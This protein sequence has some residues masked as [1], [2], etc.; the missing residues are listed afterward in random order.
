MIGDR[1]EGGRDE[2]CGEMIQKVLTK[3]TE[4]DDLME[5]EEMRC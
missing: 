3:I 2:L 1:R 4:E 5:M